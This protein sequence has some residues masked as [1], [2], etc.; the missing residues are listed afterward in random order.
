MDDELKKAVQKTKAAT[1]NAFP[2]ERGL[3]KTLLIGNPNYFGNLSESPFKPVV[4]IT[5]NTHYE[6]LACVGYHPQQQSLEA[7]VYILQ[8][9]GYGTDICGPGTS[10]SGTRPRRS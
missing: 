10:G 8:P 6:D 1:L 2:N 3:F 5:Y 7:V 4:P 9:S